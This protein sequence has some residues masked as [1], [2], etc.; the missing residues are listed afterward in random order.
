MVTTMSVSE[1]DKKLKTVRKRSSSAAT[2]SRRGCMRGKG[3][4]E[5]SLC[6]Y[7]GVRQRTWGKWV[8]EIR[9][10]NRGA[11]LWLGTYNTSLE[12]AIAYD[13][14]AFELYGS[15]AKLNLPHHQFNHQIPVKSSPASSS[16][17]ST[18]TTTSNPST[19]ATHMEENQQTRPSS[20]VVNNEECP[21]LGMG[22]L[23]GNSMEEDEGNSVM[24]K[25]EEDDSD[26]IGQY[27]ENLSLTFSDDQDI[28]R[29]LDT[30][31]MKEYAEELGG[32]P[33]VN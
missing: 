7:R 13:K 4:P 1:E 27:W 3:G 17:S 31:M 21:D 14:T 25:M 8:A 6:K 26:Q 19:Q 32:Y 22:S 15:S 29:S 24:Y 28:F 33:S 20:T 11:R 12:A 9:E 10:P 23:Q 2:K 16:F 30:P 18:T 5:N